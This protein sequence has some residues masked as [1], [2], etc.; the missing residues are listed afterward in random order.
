MQ[1]HYSAVTSL[2]LVP[3]GNLLLTAGRDKVANLWDV[4]THKKLAT[5]PVFEAIEG[6]RD[7]RFTCQPRPRPRCNNHCICGAAATAT[8]CTEAC[9]IIHMSVM[10]YKPAFGARRL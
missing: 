2:S 8:V 9:K 3:E 1:D 5:I 7:R 6:E 10:G 4:D